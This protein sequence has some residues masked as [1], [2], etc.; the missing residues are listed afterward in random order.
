MELHDPHDRVIYS[1]IKAEH[2]STHNEVF[3]NDY[4]LKLYNHSTHEIDEC[5]HFKPPTEEAEP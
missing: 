2:F 4:L 5:I 3:V 1:R